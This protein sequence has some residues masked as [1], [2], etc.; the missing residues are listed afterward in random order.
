M[1]L[2]RQFTLILLVGAMACQAPL[3]Q[4]PGTRLIVLSR[5]ENLARVVDP[6]SGA[7]LGRMVT[8]VGPQEV[9]VSGPVAVVANHGSREN[10]GFSLTVLDLRRMRALRTISLGRFRRPFGVRFLSDGERVLV[11]AEGSRSVLVVNIRSGQI[12]KAIPTLQDATHQLAVSADQLRIFVSDRD[13]GQVVL[14]DL[15]TSRLV[16]QARAGKSAEGIAVAPDDGTVWVADRTGHALVVLDPTE[17]SVM[18]RLSCRESPFRLVFTPGGEHLLVTN[19]LSADLAVFSAGERREILRLPL[20]WTADERAAGIAVDR[21]SPVPAGIAVD[22]EGS[23]AYVSHP[24]SDLV[25][26]VDLKRWQVVRRLQVPGRPD[27]L[28]SFRLM[29]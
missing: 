6:E 12:E 10:P 4:A 8:G 18:D 9:T 20:G 28:A 21:L 1:M 14:L 15:E 13:S 5:A 16:F 23:W 24:S 29:P 19:T 2:R 27:G 3:P 11:A 25:S 22:P 26:V 17:L 7:M